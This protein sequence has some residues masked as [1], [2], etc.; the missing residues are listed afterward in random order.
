MKRILTV[1]VTILLAGAILAAWLHFRVNTVVISDVSKGA[2]LNLRKK[3]SKGN[4][5][6]LELRI[7]GTIDGPAEILLTADR[8]TLHRAQ[9][10]G[11][12]GM[13]WTGDCYSDEVQ[14]QYSP[15]GVTTGRLQLD[16]SFRD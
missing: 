12:E 13:N 7:T 11:S 10:N 8:E 5:H 15:N 16:Y 6:S 14:V 2:S 1:A 4:V 9:L 3:A